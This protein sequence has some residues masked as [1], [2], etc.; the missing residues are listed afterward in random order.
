AA[1]ACRVSLVHSRNQ[2][3]RQPSWWPSACGGHGAGHASS[4]PR[5]W[6]G[7][8]AQLVEIACELAQQAVKMAFVGIAETHE[9]RLDLRKQRRQHLLHKA[10]SSGGDTDGD[11]SPI[12]G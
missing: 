11:A 8:R 7:G 6:L 10:L 3:Q 12:S 2:R 9:H 4:E 1:W 5:S